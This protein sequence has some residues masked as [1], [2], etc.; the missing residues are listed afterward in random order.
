MARPKTHG[1]SVRGHIDP[2][3]R[4]WAAM[5]SRCTNPNSCNYARW[6]GRG[7]TVCERWRKFENFLADMG[8][9]PAGKSLDRWPDNNGNY[10]PGNCRWATPKE[11]SANADHTRSEEWKDRHR[12]TCPHGVRPT[13]DCITCRRA[14]GA[15]Y[16]RRKRLKAKL[17]KAV[18]I[19][20]SVI[21]E[22]GLVP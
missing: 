10:E 8:E 18:P 6:G 9:R 2:L 13:D 7:I 22:P 16:M 11:Q 5:W 20:T 4:T 19:Q 3:Y 1:R 21:A 17:A 12:K 14:W 15:A